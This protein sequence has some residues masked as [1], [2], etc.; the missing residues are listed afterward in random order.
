LRKGWA[1]GGGGPTATYI[2]PW[3]AAEKV[4]EFERLEWKMLE[5]SCTDSIVLVYRVP[6]WVADHSANYFAHEFRKPKSGGRIVFLPSLR[7]LSL[8]LWSFFVFEIN[9]IICTIHTFNF[10]KVPSLL[11]L[12]TPA[13]LAFLRS[14]S[15]WRYRRRRRDGSIPLTRFLPFCHR[16]GGPVNTLSG[17]KEKLK[18]RGKIYISSHW[19]TCDSECP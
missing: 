11:K 9:D 16:V 3:R 15:W 5:T 10:S 19:S 8:S 1:G 17:I 14:Q 13:R 4:P 6:R 7:K 18:R 12:T 2:Y